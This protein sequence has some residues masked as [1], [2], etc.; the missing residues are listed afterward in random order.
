VSTLLDVVAAVLLLAGVALTLL[1]AIGLLRFP[2]A[3]T[4]MHAQTKPAVFGLMLVLAGTALATRSIGLGATLL[5]V[6]G[7]QLLTAPVG[8]HAIGRAAYEG[9][10]ADRARLVRDDFAARDDEDDPGAR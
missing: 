5:L 3:L 2:D 9:G 7:F 6:A 10:Q 1:A 4:R 8:A